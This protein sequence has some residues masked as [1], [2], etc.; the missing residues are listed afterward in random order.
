VQQAPVV[1]P[2]G[3]WMWNGTSWVP[4]TTVPRIAQAP[5]TSP[6]GLWMWNGAQWVPNALAHVVPYESASFRA[7]L[8]TL[9]I[10]INVVGLMLVMAFDI[11][12]WIR[13]ALGDPDEGT[14]YLTTGFVA[15]FALV[16]FYGSF[17]PAVVFFCVWLHR[18]VRN[19]PS[20]G[21]P[22]PRF[23]PGWAVGLC[24]VPFVNLVQPWVS[25]VDAWRGSPP[26]WRW[27]DRAARGAVPVSLVIAAWWIPWLVARPF[28]IAAYLL[29]SNSAVAS[30][31]TDLIGNA[32]VLVAAIF[33]ILVVRRLTARQDTRNQLIA[34]GQL[35]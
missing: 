17:I 30:A 27:L 12:Q 9:F 13:G 16:G 6:D 22:N 10:A 25:V 19:M 4:N 23:S 2:D 28:T 8:T 5:M 14:L 3:Y 34:S 31:V 11:L 1:S 29:S 26:H 20:L 32:L 35:V 7:M 18:I 33:A 15:L 24:F 21:A